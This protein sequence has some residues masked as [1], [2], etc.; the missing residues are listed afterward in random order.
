M[1]ERE[2][3][4][5]PGKQPQDQPGKQQP[6]QQKPGQRGEN[7]QQEDEDNGQSVGKVPEPQTDDPKKSRD[8]T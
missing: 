3:Q 7:P 8:Q 5:Q 6:G 4:G 1:E 2:Q